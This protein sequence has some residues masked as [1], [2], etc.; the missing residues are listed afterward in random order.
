[1]EK[2]SACHHL[3]KIELGMM[4]YGVRCL[5]LETFWQ[6]YRMGSHSP[7]RKNLISLEKEL[8]ATKL[9]LLYLILKHVKKCN[10]R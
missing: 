9:K 3:T 8:K 4:E 2:T 10:L 7:L 5:G 1:M 6:Q